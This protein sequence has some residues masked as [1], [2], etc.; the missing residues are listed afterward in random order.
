M[1]VVAEKQARKPYD[2]ALVIDRSGSMSGPPLLE[3]V[4]R[5]KHIAD[6]LEPTD[7]AS[8]VVFDDGVQT[9]SSR[10]AEQVT[11][12][13]ALGFVRHLLLQAA[14]PTCTAAWS[15]RCRWPVARCCSCVGPCH[16]FDLNANV[17]DIMNT[18]SMPALCAQAAERGVTTSTDCLGTRLQ[19]GTDGQ[20][21]QARWRNYYYGEHHLTSSS[22]SATAVRFHLV[23]FC[24]AATS[25]CRWRLRRGGQCPSAQRLS[26]RWRCRDSGEP[27]D[28]AFG[29]EAGPVDLE[30]PAGLL[31]VRQLLQGCCFC[32][33]AEK[34]T[35]PPIEWYC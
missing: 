4:R 12:G 27:A 18:A 14:P 32:F 22:P 8:L 30:I 33:D 25:V 24:G 17:G 20:D 16:C 21:G 31:E 10:L 19:R 5:A 2:L 15:G 6:Q 13:V 3:A 34:P 1:R 29:A 7:T 11:A 28:I 35:L 9:T 26:G 23:G